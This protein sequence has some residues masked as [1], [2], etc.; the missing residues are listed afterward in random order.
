MVDAWVGKIMGSIFCKENE[1][2][3]ERF[4]KRSRGRREM[5]ALSKFNKSR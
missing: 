5:L 3:S 2:I 1:N 4:Q